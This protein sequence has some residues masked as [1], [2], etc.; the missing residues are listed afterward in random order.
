MRAML[1][2]AGTPW[3][4]LR[5][6]LIFVALLAL[7]SAALAV[8]VFGHT[9]NSSDTFA[10]TDCTQYGTT[11]TPGTLAA[12][13]A[14]ASS[15]S[16]ATIA[17]D[18][19]SGGTIIVPATIS[20]TTSV[21]FTAGTTSATLSGDD[22][23]AVFA[24]SSGITATFSG[25]TIAHGLT[26]AGNADGAALLDDGAT[27]TLTD[28][29]LSDNAARGYYSAGGALYNY[30]GNVTIT[31]S[32][33]S[34]N[35]AE[36]AGAG[37][38][39]SGL[40]GAIFNIG[41]GTITITNSTFSGNTA[42]GTEGGWGGALNNAD[43]AST[44]TAVN[45]TFAG[46]IAQT[47][48][49]ALYLNNGA[50]TF[51]NVLL[52]NASGG[53]NCGGLYPTDGGYNLED[54]NTCGFSPASH[55]LINVS[56]P[57]IGALGGYG[58]PTATI[59]LEPGSPAINAGNIATC[60]AV[61]QRGTSRPQGASCAIGAFELALPSGKLSVGNPSYTPAAGHPIYVTDQ[62]PL[63]LSGVDAGS[64]VGSISYCLVPQGATC[65]FTTTT[66]LP[67]VLTISGAD[68]DYELEYY[69]SDSAGDAGRT[70]SA[71]LTTDNTAPTSVLGVSGS[72]ITPSDP[73]TI[74]ASDTGSGV[75]SIAYRYYAQGDTA[76][77]Y[78]VVKGATTSFTISGA[79]G[80]Y[81]V[82]WYAVDQVGNAEA[83]HSQ[84][85]VLVIP[86][87]PTPSP[88]PTATTP[89]N[90]TPTNTPAQGN[91]GGKTASASPTPSPSASET[92][93]SGATAT[94]TVK[95]L[96][97][98]APPA[99]STPAAPISTLLLVIVLAVLIMAIGA[100]VLVRRSRTVQ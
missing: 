80:A 41:G 59:P 74:T 23:T 36:G 53:H 24:L 17:F 14:G 11:D 18:C 76:P 83:A 4:N 98:A 20:L 46:N 72:P 95:P 63:T 71:T 93:S 85:V 62:T 68:G 31:A 87:T 26:T 33:F 38:D 12:A 52:A 82:E 78:T 77:A 7:V 40:G 100:F 88:K 6:L 97:P 22:K 81:V 29:T 55:D 67:V 37:S 39:S 2:V 5:L 44:I 15:V 43:A 30:G 94:P 50:T 8:A 10:V 28:M 75:Q 1:T 34:G 90:P 96:P 84:T 13:L 9:L 54:A 70:S 64:G 57:K 19:T 3:R 25:L 21:N 32:T 51:S 99:S 60:P 79:K 56:D 58:G 35:T 69:A 61:D 16:G 86:P 65:A 47:S 42:S 27:L 91:G 73:L 49:A 66:H 45:A 92:P 89:P 48:G